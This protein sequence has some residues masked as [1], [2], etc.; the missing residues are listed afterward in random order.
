MLPV[1]SLQRG[2]LSSWARVRDIRKAL[3]QLIKLEDYYLFIVIQA[4]SWDTAMRKVKNVKKDFASLG[5][6][7]KGSGVQTVFS[8][9]P[10][11]S[12]YPGRWRRTRQ[13]NDWLTG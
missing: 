2:V 7:L 9:L 11:G 5:K 6:M 10:M 12:W 4:G 8:V 1:Q 13:V 3:P